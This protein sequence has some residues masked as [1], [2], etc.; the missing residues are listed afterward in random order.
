M[1]IPFNSLSNY[2]IG[3]IHILAM[4]ISQVPKATVNFKL[5]RNDHMLHYP[6]SG[7]RTYTFED[8]SHVQLSPGDIL[9]LPYKANYVSTVEGTKDAVGYN[10]RFSLIDGEG[11]QVSFSDLPRVLVSDTSGSLFPYFREVAELATTTN[12][13]VRMAANLTELLDRIV[14]VCQNTPDIGW[15]SQAMNYMGSNLQRPVTLAELSAVCHMSERNFCRLF[16]DATGV[17]PIAW[18]RQLRIRKAEEF[19]SS[20]LC[21]LE[22]LAELLGFTDAAHLSRTFFRET[23][24]HASQFMSNIQSQKEWE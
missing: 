4:R 7:I 1:K 14:S 3:I 6:V 12:N 20:G 15:L 9:L 5:G 21:T 11:N 16:K 19:L 17:S 22:N 18:H 8:G 10:I 2:D 13:Y 23:G 24:I